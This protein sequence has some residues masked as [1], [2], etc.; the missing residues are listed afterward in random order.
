MD[1]IVIIGNG[2][3]GV[4]AARHIRKLSDKKITIISGESE[5]FWSRTALMY[6]Y[7]GHLKYE[8][9]KPYEDWFW[10]KNRIDLVQDWVKSIDFS[11]KKCILESG[12]AIEYSQLIIATGSTTKFHGWRGQESKAV[13]GM[14]SLQ[15]L[16]QIEKYAQ[17]NDVCK[18]AVLVGGGLIGVELAEMLHTRK[19][20][21]TFLVREKGFWAGTLP[22]Q[23]AD[24]ISREIASH[25]INLLHEEELAE[26]FSDES[27]KV[28]SVKTKSGKILP[29]D[30]LGICS[31]VKPNIDWLKNTPLDC[32]EGILV[33]RFLKTNQE[34]VYAIGDCAQQREAV[35]E[36]KS[37][38]AVW[39]TGRMMGETVAQTICNNPTEWN[40]GIWFNSAKFFNI[41]YQTYGRVWNKPK[42]ENSHY[43][44][45]CETGKR[46][47]DIEFSTSNRKV[48]GINTFGIRMKHNVWDH[49]LNSEKTIDFTIENLEKACFDPEFNKTPL[50][51]IKLHFSKS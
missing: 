7:M 42:E 12:E 49:W 27:G 26:I 23:S 5:H 14:V 24:L 48:V 20:P 6:I 44:W 46:A 39:Y 16:E 28:S 47:M 40:P 2:I 22:Q 51:K 50:Q 18:N 4:T 38:E 25:G 17:N 29:C 8:H 13:V 35:R 34:N 33:D 11:E 36:R 30:F 32:D 10:K 9:T 21:V 31:G 15:D 41:E 45:E 37:V 3:A 43:H 1:H 19:I